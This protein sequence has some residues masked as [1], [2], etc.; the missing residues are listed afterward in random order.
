MLQAARIAPGGMV[1]FFKSLEKM[2]LPE[3][4]TYLSTHPRSEDRIR[5]LERLAAGMEV[6]AVPLLPEVSWEDVKLRCAPGG[7]AREASP[8]TDTQEIVDR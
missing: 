1:D 5:E 8:G 4:L 7:T 6:D 2:D 3:G